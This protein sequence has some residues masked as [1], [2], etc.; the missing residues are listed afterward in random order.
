MSYG[1]VDTRILSNVARLRERVKELVTEV[2]RVEVHKARLLS[3]IEH[4]D[5]EASRLLSEEAKRL[6]VPDNT[7][8]RITEDGKAEPVQ[9]GG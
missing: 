4:L 8:W 7:P 6:G 2:G 1:Q 5:G 3:E 9:T